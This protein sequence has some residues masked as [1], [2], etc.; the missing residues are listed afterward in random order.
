MAKKTFLEKFHTRASTKVIES[1]LSIIMIAICAGIVYLLYLSS[2]NQDFTQLNT[3]IILQL[4]QTI[5][6]IA[7]IYTGIKI[8]EIHE[9][10]EIKKKK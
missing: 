3:I 8:W 2:L 4:F 7:L 1:F 5:I 9:F 6:L 10:P